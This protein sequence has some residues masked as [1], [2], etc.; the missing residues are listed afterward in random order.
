VTIRKE[1]Q[2]LATIPSKTTSAL[3]KAEWHE[4]TA[5]PKGRVR[6]DLQVEI[7]V[8]PQPNHARA[9]NPEWFTHGKR[10]NTTV[11]DDIALLHEKKQPVTGWHT[12][13]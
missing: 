13:T 6:K 5:E 8:I 11:A 12:S 1:D 9:E 2:T 4:G 7:V 3:Q 10:K